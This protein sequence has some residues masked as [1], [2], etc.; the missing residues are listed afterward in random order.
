M[1][2]FIS[3]FLLLLCIPTSLVYANE[4]EKN[5]HILIQDEFRSGTHV[6]IEEDQDEVYEAVKKG[7]IRPF[8]ELYNTIDKQLNGRL[9]KIELEEDD[10]EWIYEIKLIHNDNVVKVEYNAATLNMIK[11][12]ARN[13]IDI[14]KK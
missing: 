12:E 4:V 2:N 3:R 5:G 7:L 6:N 8:S 1:L 9:I 13:I 14:I 11:I 10:D